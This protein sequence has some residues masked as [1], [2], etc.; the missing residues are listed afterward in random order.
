M[1]KKDK[2][3]EII[4]AL[5]LILIAVFAILY[6]TTPILWAVNKWKWAGVFVSALVKL[7]LMY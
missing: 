6:F 4:S 3:L 1:N 7:H 5:F 2:A